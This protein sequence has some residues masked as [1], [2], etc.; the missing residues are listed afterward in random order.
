MFV[1]VGESRGDGREER[2][3]GVAE[4]VREEG[5]ELRQKPFNSITEYR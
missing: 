1:G 3:N 5:V 2:E 4:A